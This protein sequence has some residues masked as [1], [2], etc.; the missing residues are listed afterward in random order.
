[1]GRHRR[2]GDG[3]QQHG[4]RQKTVRTGQWQG[5]KKW[6]VVRMADWRQNKPRA[7]WRCHRYPSPHEH[8]SVSGFSCQY[9]WIS[10]KYWGFSV[11]K[12]Q[13]LVEGCIV[14]VADCAVQIYAAC[15]KR[16]SGCTTAG[17]PY[18]RTPGFRSPKP[19]SEFRTRSQL[20]F[21]GNRFSHCCVN[22]CT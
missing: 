10:A 9:A 3:M 15:Q 18:Q 12:L 6:A 19:R 4:G 7:D 20:R 2:W 13:P 5:G 11:L 16:T 17:S 1:M 21:T 8:W 22:C 14:W